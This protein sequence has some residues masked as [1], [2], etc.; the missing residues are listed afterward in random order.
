MQTGKSTVKDIFDGTRIFSV[1][2]YQR[3]YSWEREDN[4][5]DFFND[6]CSQHPD[7]PYFLGSFLFHLNG[8]KSEFALVDIVDGQ[9]RLTTLVIFMHVLLGKLISQ[10][11]TLISERTRRIFVRDGDVFKLESANEGNAFLHDLVLGDRPPATEDVTLRTHSQRLLLDARQYFEAQLARHDLAMLERVYT[12][13]IN[14]DVLLYVVDKISTA[15]QIFELLNDRGRRLTDLE[16]IKSFLMYNAGI[17]YDHPEQVIGKIQEDF[18]EIYRLIESHNINDRDVLRY[19]TLAFETYPSD[20]TDKPKAYI[21][22]KIL[23]LVSDAERRE[24]AR[25]Q[26]RDYPAR[27]KKSFQLFA[28]I[29]DRRF[30]DPELAKTFMIGRVAPFY[31]ALMKVHSDRPSDFPRLVKTINAFTFRSS[32][33]RLRSN[34]ESYQYTCLRNDKDVIEVVENFVLG[35]W[36]NINGRAREAF[37]YNNYYDWLEKNVVRYILFSYENSLRRRKGFPLLSSRD[38]ASKDAREKLSIEH[39]TAKKALSV[40]FD[41]DFRENYLNN[42]GNLVIDHAASNSSKGRK[43]GD[44]KV[45]H[46]NL[47]PLMSQ[48][49]INEGGCDWNDLESIKKF[50]HRREEKLKSEVSLEF[51]I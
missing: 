21:K 32:L 50:I 3:A 31:P 44:E 30:V 22:E 6:L 45:V 25:E 41:D 5:E 43:G 34:G 11:S 10:G 24:E 12:T 1:P 23:G 46:Y 37:D 28:Q 18:A 47:A 33:A 26:I 14:A 7:R 29:R 48:N 42:L 2:T 16:S 40:E 17:V 19:H 20:Y 38:Y 51:K 4:L 35:N 36:W 49:E 15:T 27:L 39:I 13:A 8:N 9:Q